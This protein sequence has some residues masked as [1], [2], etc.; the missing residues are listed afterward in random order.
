MRL[1]L[2]IERETLFGSDSKEISTTILILWGPKNAIRTSFKRNS[3][4]Y[5]PSLKVTSINKL[6]W[7]KLIWRKVG[8]QNTNMPTVE[9]VGWKN[10]TLSSPLGQPTL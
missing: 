1:Q 2:L 9:K 5:T 10:D 3:L 8:F 6:F 7:H 4:R